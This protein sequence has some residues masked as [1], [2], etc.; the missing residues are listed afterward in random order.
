MQLDHRIAILSCSLNRGGTCS[1]H[2]HARFVGPM[3]PG[4]EFRTLGS[5]QPPTGACI[6]LK[7][8][9]KSVC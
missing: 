8:H 3:A 9:G 2:S 1:A 7:E 4:P 5:S 6:N